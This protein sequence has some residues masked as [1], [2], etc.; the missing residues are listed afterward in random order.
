LNKDEFFSSVSGKYL[1]G[2]DLLD[3]KLLKKNLTILSS[4]E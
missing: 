4:I 1:D 2:L 3:A